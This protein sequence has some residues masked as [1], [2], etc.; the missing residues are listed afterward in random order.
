VRRFAPAALLTLAVGL[1][2]AAPPSPLPHA[3]AQPVPS[4]SAAASALP[5]P[6]STA[7]PETPAA[8]AAPAASDATALDTPEYRLQ[9]DTILWRGNGDFEM[10]HHVAFSRPGSD[11]TADS[12]TGNQKRGTATLHGNV[13]VHD[14]GNAPEAHDDEYAKGGPSTLTCDT[15]DVDSKAKIYTAIGHV[16][17]EQGKRTATAERGVLDRRTGLL[18]LEGDVKTSDGESTMTAKTLAYNLVTKK[19]DAEGAPVKILQPVPTPG[20][21]AAAKATPAPKKRRL[22]FPI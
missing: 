22:P 3:G 15:L 13:V 10:P 5:P 12:A 18:H 14:N 2:G 8:S 16:H 1:A 9:T 11:G 21:N 6:G 4:P 7:P 20:P 19:V 17:F